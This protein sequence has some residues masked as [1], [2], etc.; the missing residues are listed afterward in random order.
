MNALSAKLRKPVVWTG[1][2]NVAH[3]DWYIGL[4]STGT[5]LCACRDLATPD[6]RRDKVPGATTRER[7]SFDKTIAE[8][9]LVDLW[10]VC[11]CVSTRGLD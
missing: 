11:V 10:L 8:C 3:T 7:E 1:D 4:M 2:L 6:Q 9:R 5:D